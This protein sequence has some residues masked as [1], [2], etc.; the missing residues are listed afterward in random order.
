[1]HDSDEKV[2]RSVFDVTFD[3]VYHGDL[4]PPPSHHTCN[5]R[6]LYTHARSRVPIIRD[7]PDVKSSVVFLSPGRRLTSGRS[8]Y[9][10]VFVIPVGSKSMQVARLIC[11]IQSAFLDR[12]K[13]HVE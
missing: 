4:R 9:E 12:I 7:L 5:V 6:L 3:V 13:Q 11:Y 2:S 10:T 1:M 8:A